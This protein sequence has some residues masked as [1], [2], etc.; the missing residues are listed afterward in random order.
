MK[1][2]TRIAIIM[3]VLMIA[4]MTVSLCVGLVGG[5]V[6]DRQF[7]N[8][9]PAALAL[10]PVQ[11]ATALAWTPT[12][13]PTQ[14]PVPPTITSTPT[15]T[16]TPTDVP[17]A[18]STP[19][20]TLAAASPPASEQGLDMNLINEAWDA[21]QK[22]YVDRPA[23]QGQNLTYGAISGMVDALGDTGHSRF[24][25]ADAYKS[26]T[27][28]LRG[29]FEG[30]GVYIESKNGQVVI[31]TPIDGSPAQKAGIL[32]GD[33]IE[34]VN[35]EDISGLSLDQVV[36]RVVG[37]A[38]TQVTLTI[39]TPGTGLEREVTLTRAKITIVNVTWQAIPG[40][41]VAHL[42]IVQFSQGAAAELKK[43]LAE[44]KQQ[45]MTGIILDL[46][47]DPGGLVNEVVQASSEFLKSGDVYLEKDSAG[48][49]VNI[50]VT[51]NG[52][53]TTIPMVVLVNNG[54]ASAAE[55]MA[56]AIQDA[57]R[58]KLVGDTTF[59]T[60]TVLNEFRLS[61]GSV[62]ILAIKE[63]LTPKGRVIWHTGIKPDVE[64]KLDLNVNPLFPEAERTMTATQLQTSKDAQLLKALE[65]LKTP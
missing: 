42:R 1:A 35:G 24:L 12:P 50:P 30:I 37:P 57:G 43:A 4:G 21:L 64:V 3:G 9:M 20:P 55:I 2:T 51:G 34:K 45:N 32:P 63:W 38:G 36:S 46:R 19:T 10:V 44:I 27:G 25:T 56:G 48:N 40:T 8:R 58:G 39:I 31:V 60:G 23:L 7:L 54:S 18:T 22:Y 28:S 13:V 52:T 41:K 29:E 65:L 49:V 6:L 14:T 11:T 26:F 53:A 16:L 17:P 47:N 62:L 59:G 15:L 5:I 33:I 61:D